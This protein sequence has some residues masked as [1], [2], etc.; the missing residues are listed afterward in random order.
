[1]AKLW[2]HGWLCT[3]HHQTNEPVTH[4]S[5]VKLTE[6]VTVYIDIFD[7]QVKV[8]LKVSESISIFKYF[9]NVFEI[10]IQIH[11]F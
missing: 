3:H 6:A 7:E 8:F 5:V 2:L 9:C 11:L 4:Y 1:M 10:Q